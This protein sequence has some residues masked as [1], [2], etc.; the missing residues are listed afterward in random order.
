V[1]ERLR[2]ATL[3]AVDNVEVRRRLEASGWRILSMSPEETRA[4]VKREAEKWPAILRQA[5]IKP[6]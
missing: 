6:E 4:F 1:I 3:K 2:M 5:G